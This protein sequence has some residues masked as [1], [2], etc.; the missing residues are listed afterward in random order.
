[1][2]KS[3][4][5][6]LDRHVTFSVSLPAYVK[7]NMDRRCESLQITRTDYVKQMILWDLDKGEG[8]ERSKIQE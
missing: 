4:H 5:Q 7:A 1:M 8:A 2:P 6:D 3:N